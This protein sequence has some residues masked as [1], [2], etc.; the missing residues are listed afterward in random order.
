MGPTF[1]VALSKRQ[2][3][4]RPPNWVFHKEW[5]GTRRG[6]IWEC[7]QFPYVVTEAWRQWATVIKEWAINYMG[8]GTVTVVSKLY[9]KRH[10]DE[11]LRRILDK[12]TDDL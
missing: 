3:Y 4:L 7:L 6:K 5:S 2:I 11:G 9:S 1:K 8:M 10:N 12:V